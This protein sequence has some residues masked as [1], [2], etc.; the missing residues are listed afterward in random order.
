MPAVAKCRP[1]RGP[2]QAWEI[3]KKRLST[4]WRR[5]KLYMTSDSHCTKTGWRNLTFWKDISA[6]TDT[7]ISILGTHY[8]CGVTAPSWASFLFSFSF[9]FSYSFS[10]LAGP[11]LNPKLGNGPAI[12]QQFNLQ[13]KQQMWILS[14]L[15]KITSWHICLSQFHALC[16][17]KHVYVYFAFWDSDVPLNGLQS[18]LA[19][20]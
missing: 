2:P 9:S 18:C 17:N 7:L 15:K 6:E 3:W 5:I 13:V 1:T 10:P 16:Q 12:Y 20:V 8:R 4:K 19:F 11:Q 14:Q